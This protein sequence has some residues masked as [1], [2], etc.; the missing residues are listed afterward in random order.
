MRVN[1]RCLRW[2]CVYGVSK[3]VI[4]ENQALAVNLSKVSASSFYLLWEE[5]LKKCYIK[6]LYI[7]KY[8]KNFFL[9]YAKELD[10]VQLETSVMGSLLEESDNAVFDNISSYREKSKKIISKSEIISGENADLAM[11]REAPMKQVLVDKFWIFFFLN[12]YFAWKLF[13]DKLKVYSKI[14]I[15]LETTGGISFSLEGLKKS[16]CSIWNFTHGDLQSTGGI[17]LSF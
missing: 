10:L 5:I 3:M 12:L 4:L 17:E 11:N 7:I 1:L 13:K 8:K 15:P 14:S 9:E 6:F 16:L 2:S